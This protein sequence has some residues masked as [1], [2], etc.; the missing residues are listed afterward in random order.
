MNARTS[1]AALGSLLVMWVG[2]MLF[3]AT[4]PAEPFLVSPQTAH[5]AHLIAAMLTG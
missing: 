4:W 3:A 1:R 5:L 2:W